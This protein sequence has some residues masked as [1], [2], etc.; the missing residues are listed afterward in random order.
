ME[1]GIG[2]VRQSFLCG[3]TADDVLWWAKI[4]PELEKDAE[5]F[6]ATGQ[7]NRESKV[8]A[9]LAAQNL[10]ANR[11]HI[12]QAANNGDKHFFIDLGRILSGDASS[13]FWDKLDSDIAEL[14]VKNPAM[15]TAKA[16]TALVNRCHSNLEEHTVRQRKKR[17]GLTKSITANRDKSP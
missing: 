16:T 7:R 1:S 3:R 17:L 5:L 10:K 6:K 8:I 14:F 9:K 15:S 13:E 11:W 2:Y 12:V 4:A